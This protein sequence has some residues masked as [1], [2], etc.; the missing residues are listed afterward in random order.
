MAEMLEEG[1]LRGLFFRTCNGGVRFGQLLVVANAPPCGMM[2]PRSASRLELLMSGE[3]DPYYKWLGI[4]PEE[5]PADY[6]RLLGLRLFEIDPE[7]IDNAAAQRMS[8]LRTFH[9]GQHQ[10]RSQEMLNELS[11]ARLCLLDEDRKREYDAQLRQAQ[12]P[13]PPPN[14]ADFLPPP[15]LAPAPQP[16]SSPPPVV[17]TARDAFDHSFPPTS[18]G[19][20][21]PELSVPIAAAT[22][23]SDA[24]DLPEP[25]EKSLASLH[26]A[27]PPLSSDATDFEFADEEDEEADEPARGSLQSFSSVILSAVVHMA[28]FIALAL[29]LAPELINKDPL[30]NLLIVEIMPPSSDELYTSDAIQIESDVAVSIARTNP[31]AGLDTSVRVAEVENSLLESSFN[32]H[33]D[34]SP[35]ALEGPAFDGTELENI[36]GEVKIGGLGDSH[37]VVDNYQQVLDR[38]TQEVLVMARDE[39]L[40]LVWLFDQSASMKDDQKE[41]HDR[42]ENVYV[43]LREQAEVED[44]AIETVVASFG[45]HFLLNTSAPTTDRLEIRE[46]LAGVPDDPS[47]K[48]MLCQ[49]ILHVMGTFGQYAKAHGRTLAIFVV[50]DEAG[51]QQDN[52]VFLEPTIAQA[53]ASGARIYVIGR[54][55]AFGAP[56]AQMRWVHPLNGSEYWLPVDRGPE[57][58]FVEQL[59]TDGFGKRI[60]V[61]PSGFGPYGQCRLAKETGGVFFMLPSQEV[62]LVRGESRRFELRV[63]SEYRPDL[64]S[65]REVAESSSK[66]RLRVVLTKVINDINPY[67]EEVSDITEVRRSYSAKPDEFFE[68]AVKEKQKAAAYLA[69]LDAAIKELEKIEGLRE[70]ETS[71]RWQANYDLA[72]AQLLAYAARTYEYIAT[73]DDFVKKPNK[74]PLVKAPTD[75]RP[76][77]LELRSWEVELDEGII[78]H[79]LAQDLIDRSSEVFWR[80]LDEHEG[81]PWAARA[82]WEL[83]RGFGVKLT[84]RYRYVAP[85]KPKPVKRPGAGGGNSGG[86]R[87]RPKPNKPKPAGPVIVIPKAL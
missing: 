78:R 82:E 24:W 46:A 47:G 60:D 2:S 16:P 73:V 59:Q 58:A 74:V 43:E 29:M 36:L 86:G 31:L 7:V 54:E 65:R 32:K 23:A 42:I 37:A 20:P 22:V 71:L 33:E 21:Q 39:K 30:D 68:Q 14:P 70:E 18:G 45:E 15:L 84:E 77:R 87:T 85:P 63:L 1:I 19:D 56:Y 62:N 76:G 35:R 34:I 27:A 10:Q 48:E 26:Q 51:E 81:T 5:Q 12:H 9:L 61:H 17:P 69:Y 72:Y 57:S 28:V 41:I 38:I 66:D 67:R 8:H 79:E 13:P 25:E 80:I 11:K 52:Q 53:K 75:G 3:F 49:A 6:Y 44:D 40:L 4:P 83:T 50:T 64:R 55:A